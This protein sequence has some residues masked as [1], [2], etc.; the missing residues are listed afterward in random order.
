MTINTI[1]DT[2]EAALETSGIDITIIDTY[3]KTAIEALTERDYQITETVIS[4]LVDNDLVTEEDALFH[5]ERL[6]LSVR[7][8]PE[9]EP[10]VEEEVQ[11]EVDSDDADGKLNAILAGLSGISTRLEKLENAAEANGI[12]L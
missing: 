1:N 7:P 6:G 10:E 12:S 5:A 2:I 8:Q 4:T 3:A 9:P 11:V